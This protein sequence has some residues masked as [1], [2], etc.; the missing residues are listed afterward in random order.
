M[1][2]I[3]LQ[4]HICDRHNKRLEGETNK[5]KEQLD[6]GDQRDKDLQQHIKELERKIELMEGKVKW[7]FGFQP[8]SLRSFF[9]PIY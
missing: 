5:L 7:M 9:S 4:N 1:T 6:E 3:T 2:C 8:S